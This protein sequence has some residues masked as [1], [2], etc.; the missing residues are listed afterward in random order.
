MPFQLLKEIALQKDDE[1]MVLTHYMDAFSKD[2]TVKIL[3][4]LVDVC[5]NSIIMPGNG[6][7]LPFHH[8]CLN[9]SCTADILMLSLHFCSDCIANNPS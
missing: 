3:H 7:M 2:I 5:P 8:A 4:F 9:A 1:G 6:R